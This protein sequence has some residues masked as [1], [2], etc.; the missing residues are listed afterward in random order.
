MSEGLHLPS[1]DWLRLLGGDPRPWLLTS[2]EPAARWIALTEILDRPPDDPEVRAAHAEVRQDPGVRA[3][4]EQ[5]PDWEADTQLSGHA[6]PAFAPNLLHLL[7]DLGLQAGD[8][9]RIERLLDSMLD[10]QEP[11][12]R[13]ASF[14]RSRASPEAAW[15]ALLCDT[16]AVT[17]ALVRYGRTDDPRTVAALQRM[18][19]D[20]G[21]TSQG[22]A[23]P[24]V[25]HS[26]S[27]FRGP[28]RK[29]D[30]CPQV[31]L[32]ALRTF[33]R[34]P[35]AGQP[36]GLFEAARVSLRAW[37][38]RGAEK[39]YLF[40]HGMRFK[41]AKWPMFW[42]DVH[43]V[44]DT[45]SRYPELWREPAAQPADRTAMAELAACL[46][47][48]NFN[49]DGCVTPRSCYRGFERFSFGQKKTPSPFA[50]AR[51]IAVLHR[52]GD[53]AGEIETVDV[54]TLFS[55]KGRSAVALPPRPSRA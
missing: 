8:D 18:A 50:T 24:C 15:G 55:S 12:G 41:T 47:A 10:H 16:H 52:L 23:W 40:G 25:P 46:V 11:N 13:F 45:L 3:L 7:A 26:V 32:E 36:H 9:P 17:E 43:W 5:L 14:G 53:L 28:G 44:L 48:Y 51:L 31:T 1:E 27:G 6:S 29:S 30:F 54:L 42:Y 38:A 37:S 34:L 39:P 20:L 19:A 22:R 4:I 21:D 33:A 49:P 35:A 2:N